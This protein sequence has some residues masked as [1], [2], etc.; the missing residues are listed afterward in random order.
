MSN[1]AQKIDLHVHSPASSDFLGAKTDGEYISILKE[2]RRAGV[3]AIAL[4]DHNTVNGCIAFE[5][6]KCEARLNYEL[7]SR[8]GGA[9]EFLE[10]LKDEL[11]LFESISLI[12]GVE[13]SVYPKIHLILLFDDQV[14]LE[15]VNDFLK[16]DL[17]LGDVVDKGSPDN[18]FT[19]APTALLK[20]ATTKF[21]DQ[22]FCILPYVDS[23]N[24]A[25]N[26]LSGEP[27]AELFRSPEVLAV[28]VLSPETKRHFQQNWG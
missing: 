17:N 13:I 10:Q 19:Q 3:S 9:K 25:W 24:G 27:R 20:L 8:R 2:C 26:E 12:H 18:Y 16:L 28:Q 11:L 5:R 22:F 14:K 21:G 1:I 15:T 7:N 23:S 4:T 6:L